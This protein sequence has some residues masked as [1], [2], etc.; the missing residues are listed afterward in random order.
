MRNNFLIKVKLAM[1]PEV[2]TNQI[3]AREGLDIICDWFGLGTVI[4]QQLFYGW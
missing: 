4:S 2:Q 1:N 3:K